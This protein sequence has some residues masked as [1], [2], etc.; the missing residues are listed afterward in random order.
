[1]PRGVHARRPVP[2]PLP[3]AGSPG[4]SASV[5]YAQ[6]PRGPPEGAGTWRRA[7]RPASKSP[8]GD[9]TT[10][11]AVCA[12][13]APL[14]DMGLRATRRTPFRGHPALPLP[15]VPRP[16]YVPIN[17]E[18][19][20]WAMEQAGVNDVELAERCGT[21]PD[22]VA[23]W[24]EGELH[25]T[26]TQFNQLVARLR[27]P[28]GIYFLA[29]APEDDPVIRAFRGPPGSQ[30]ARTLTDA[31]VRALQTAERLQKVARWVRGHRGDAEVAIPR[32]APDAPVSGLALTRAHR[33]LEWRV[34]D[35]FAASST[36]EAA[37]LLRQRLESVGVLVLH[38]SMKREGCRGF[39]L[40]DDVAPVIA[41]NSAY[42]T[43]ARIF[44]YLHEYAH[45]AHGAGSICSKL[46]DSN[47][48]RRCEGFAA[49]F[50]MPKAALERYIDDSFGEGATIGTTSEVA[51]IA[52]RFKVSLRAAAYR[53]ER[54]N[55]AR[56]GLYHRVDKDADFKGGSGYSQDTGAPA[57]RL[58][59]WG[60]G[61]AELL[62]EAER[63]GLLGRT[64]V[65]EYMNL[66][67]GEL[68]DLR[69]RVAV[70]A[71]AEG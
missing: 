4:V 56:S 26:K 23:D 40:Y 46:P 9:T 8:P 29:E 5:R 30:R 66:S 35:Q 28:S 59:E 39:S 33:F 18:V 13:T 12:T 34:N 31:E 62:F 70:G 36:P 11:F 6:D 54:I 48:E 58:R 41:V 22:V 15:P 10:S 43:G 37:R 49:A 32:V 3:G 71:G 1:V 16:T 45:L 25:P 24:R 53:L 27:R 68:S 67:N 52:R 65:L 69:A 51:R 61:Y 50:L 57:I 2:P 17:G 60:A 44:S 7:R 63:R 42:T 38:F 19:L 20:E 47:L 21:T 64:D 14:S 55:R